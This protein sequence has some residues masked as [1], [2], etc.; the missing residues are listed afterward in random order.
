MMTYAC[1][2]TQ[3]CVVLGGGRLQVFILHGMVLIKDKEW[4]NVLQASYVQDAGF[5]WL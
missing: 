4:E 3:Q 2:F 5:L 1:G